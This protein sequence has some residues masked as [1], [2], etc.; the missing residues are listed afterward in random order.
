MWSSEGPPFEEVE[1]LISAYSER[2]LIDQSDTGL[3]ANGDKIS[4]SE[5]CRR[6]HGTKARDP[7]LIFALK[8]P[9]PQDPRPPLAV[10]SSQR[11]V[12][13]RLDA[14]DVP[15]PNMTHRR[16]DFS[17]GIDGTR[18]VLAALLASPCFTA[19]SHLLTGREAERRFAQCVA[20]S[21]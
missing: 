20:K 9:A 5:E 4:Q 16:I 8:T 19:K 11:L 18:R 15:P 1:A 10:T 14:T 17:S 13:T 6:P 3:M 12:W 2:K 7:P 21:C